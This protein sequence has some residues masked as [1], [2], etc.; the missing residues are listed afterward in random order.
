MML[1]F[2]VTEYR[3]LFHKCFRE[4]VKSCDHSG[5]DLSENRNPVEIF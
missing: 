1:E 3:A 2:G 5:T 4:M